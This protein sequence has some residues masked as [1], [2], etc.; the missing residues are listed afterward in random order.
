MRRR[1]A[2][3]P[4]LACALASILACAR[5]TE[6]AP[7]SRP[8]I[9]ARYD[10]PIIDVHAHLRTGADDGL[11]PSQP[12]GTAALRALEQAAGVTRAGLIVIARAGAIEDTRRRNDAVI[13]A[14]RDSDGFFFAVASVHP[15]DGE[16][17]LAELDRVAAAGVRMIKLHPN[18]QRFALDAPELAAVV[19][20]AA[21]LGLVL[22]FDAYSPFDADQIGKFL[23]LA[24]Q[25][26]TA[27]I[28]L[29][30]LGA[31]RF[32]E[33]AVFGMVRRFAWY[34]NNVWFDLSVVAAFYAD[35]PYRDELTWVI[36]AVGID[37]VLFGSDWPVDDPALAVDAVRRLGLDAAEQRKVFH[38]NAASLLRLD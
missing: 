25:H 3:L 14:A 27:R 18:T 35:S 32:H 28:V 33:L 11:A 7:A 1:G 30:H 26:P 9:V 34:P 37:H 2:V 19:D 6:G 21:A 8:P 23:M 29:A 24:V 15:A 5:N 16:A 36:R 10:G 13:A 20:R 31:V 4:I 38:D 17:A 12:E 22:L